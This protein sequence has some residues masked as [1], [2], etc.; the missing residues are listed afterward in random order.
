MRQQSGGAKY[1]RLSL[2]SVLYVLLISGCSTVAPVVPYPGGIA[3]PR[4]IA[5]LPLANETNSVTGARMM[6]KYMHENL[7]DK[8]YIALDRE[9]IDQILSDRFGISLGEQITVNLIPE[10][11]KALKVDAVVTGV[12]KKFTRMDFFQNKIELEATFTIHEIET[13]NGLWHFQAYGASPIFA[14]QKQAQ[15][16][17]FYEN[18]FCAI[19]TGAAPQQPV[20]LPYKRNCPAR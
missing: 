4:T 11:G 9:E 3:P 20:Y 2:G 19:P 14:D 1:H 6:R 8:G 13:G 18:L 16:N 5:V 17:P 10:I 15:V 7:L 12:A